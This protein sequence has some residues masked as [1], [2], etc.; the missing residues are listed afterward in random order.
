MRVWWELIRA[1]TRRR[2]GVSELLG[3]AA[4]KKR[5]LPAADLFGLNIAVF[6]MIRLKK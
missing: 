4:E 1:G 6:L 3:C 5:R 2:R